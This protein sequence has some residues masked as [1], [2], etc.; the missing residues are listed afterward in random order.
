MI[1]APKTATEQSANIG[2]GFIS[3]PRLAVHWSFHWAARSWKG[4]IRR[5][6]SYLPP[7][8]GLKKMPGMA[9]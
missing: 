1:R 5:F 3:H 2:S 8:V 4:K 9:H 7:G 6:I